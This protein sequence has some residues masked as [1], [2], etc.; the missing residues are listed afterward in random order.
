MVTVDFLASSRLN[1]GPSKFLLYTW[2]A[3]CKKAPKRVGY[4]YWTHSLWFPCSIHLNTGTYFW[5][6]RQ[7]IFRP[8]CCCKKWFP[9]S[10]REDQ[11]NT[12]Y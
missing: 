11:I 8:H 9:R 6:R 2:A 12:A 7:T 5:E 3:F 4:S 1:I 10:D